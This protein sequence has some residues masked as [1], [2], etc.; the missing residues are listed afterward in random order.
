MAA[1]FP[2]LINFTACISP[3]NLESSKDCC[4]IDGELICGADEPPSAKPH[5][6]LGLSTVIHSFYTLLMWA[7]IVQR[8]PATRKRWFFFA[9]SGIIG[10]GLQ[11]VIW[12][13]TFAKGATKI[14]AIYTT[15]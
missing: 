3:T 14:R 13:F 11:A 1:N 7:S 5:V 4:I 8:N 15:M 10:F 12:P 6:I 9:F 2:E